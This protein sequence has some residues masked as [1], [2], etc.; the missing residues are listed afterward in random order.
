MQFDGNLVLWTRGAR[1]PHRNSKT[2]E[3]PASYLEMQTDGNLVIYNQNLIPFWDTRT[4][5]GNFV[6]NRNPSINVS[7]IRSSRL[8]P[9]PIPPA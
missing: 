6:E 2:A 5:A 8:P 4:N 3:N 9:V 1:V 7:N